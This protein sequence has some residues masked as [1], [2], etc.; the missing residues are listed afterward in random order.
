MP[1]HLERD[2]TFELSTLEKD[3]AKFT[4]ERT[5][6]QEEK[7]KLLADLADKLKEAETRAE[8]VRLEL[9]RVKAAKGG[10]PSTLAEAFATVGEHEWQQPELA[11]VPQLIQGVLT[12]I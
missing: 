12:K 9:K 6:V 10:L 4:K 3:I 11:V 5:E 8:A 1:W 2:L 7:D